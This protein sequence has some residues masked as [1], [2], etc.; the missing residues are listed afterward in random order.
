MFQDVLEG[1]DGGHHAIGVGDSPLL[2]GDIE[3]HAVIHHGHACTPML[4]PQRHRKTKTKKK[5]RER[6]ECIPIHHHRAESD[7]P[8]HHSL[9]S[10]IN[11]LDA[12]LEHGKHP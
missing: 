3:I 2:E 5:E 11:V 7:S 10:E 8:T 1:G 9:A 4:S 12:L 6:I